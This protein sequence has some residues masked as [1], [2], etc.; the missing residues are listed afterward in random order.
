MPRKESFAKLG[1]RSGHFKTN[2]TAPTTPVVTIG[3]ITTG[4]RTYRF[5]NTGDDLVTVT[6]DTDT[7]KIKSGSSADVKLL[8]G[9]S[10]TMTGT[11]VDS[12]G[13]YELLPT[14]GLR[15]GRFKRPATATN[16]IIRQGALGSFYRFYNTDK[17]QLRVTL[18]ALSGSGAVQ[19]DI[20]VG[21]SADI[22]VDSSRVVTVNSTLGVYDRVAY[23][24]PATKFIVDGTIRSG[25]FRGEVVVINLSTT[26]DT[27]LPVYRFFN[28]GEDAFDVRL[29]GVKIESVNP[30]SSVDLEINTATTAPREVSIAGT[31]PRGSYELLA[32]NEEVSP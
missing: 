18:V 17:K 21:S 13:V 2:P 15:S 31:T 30:S 10:A 25:H 9:K 3:A 28:S 7:T 12:E 24:S 19:V 27:F 20:A 23:Q 11:S 6:I 5:Y 1:S 22:F 32:V 26:F 14:A 29:N 16:I 4:D 8:T